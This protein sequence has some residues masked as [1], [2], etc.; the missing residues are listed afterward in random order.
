MTDSEVVPPERDRRK[1]E[2]V[3]FEPLHIRM[4]GTRDGIVV[5]LSEGGAL[6]QTSVAPPK[7]AQFP[8]EIE[9]KNTKVPLQA[10][11]VRSVQRQVQLES[12]TLKRTE[13]YVALEF[14]DMTPAQSAAVRLIIQGT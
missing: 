3:S 1:A 9:W 7:G 2:R 4:D 5:D 11:V 14:V 13:Y 8:I 12:A 10:R 6:L